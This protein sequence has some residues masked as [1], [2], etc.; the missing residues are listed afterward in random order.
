MVTTWMSLILSFNAHHTTPPLD[1]SPAAEPVPLY[2]TLGP[3]FQMPLNLAEDQQEVQR[4]Q[5]WVSSDGGRTWTLSEEIGRDDK[6]F[7]YSARRGGEYWFAVRLKDKKG[8]YNPESTRELTPCQRIFVELGFEPVGLEQ[9]KL[10]D[11]AVELDVELTRVELGLIRKEMER[12]SK[13]KRFR[14]DTTGL[15]SDKCRVVVLVLV[16]GFECGWEGPG[17]QRRTRSRKST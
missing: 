16:R 8:S 7:S 12:L 13:M 1:P 5:L 17:C 3:R 11:V 14:P 10:Q 4:V 15:S 6:W 9:K 2:K